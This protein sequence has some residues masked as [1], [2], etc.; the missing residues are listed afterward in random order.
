LIQGLSA[1]IGIA[2]GRNPAELSRIHF[3]PAAVRVMW[4]L[5]EKNH[6]TT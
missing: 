5:K 4:V 1:E 3:P 6:P 2:T